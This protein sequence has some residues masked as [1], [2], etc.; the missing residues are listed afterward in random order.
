MALSL[1]HIQDQK[2]ANT[3]GGTGSVGDNTRDLNTVL[4]NEISGASLASNKITL[5]AGTYMIE[6]SSPCY[7]CDQNRAFLYNVTDSAVE[8][9]GT[10]EYQAESSLQQSRSFVNGRFT[11]AGSK[12]FELRHNLSAAPSSIQVLGI[13]SND[14]R[15]EVYTDVSIRQVVA[16]IPLLHV[17][18]QKAANTAG[19]S[20]SETSW[21]TRDLN[22][23]LTNEISG[24]SL[25]SDQITLPAGT[26][27]IEANTR[28]HRGG[29][30]RAVLYNVTDSAYEIIG[31][32]TFA[33]VGGFVEN[34]TFVLGQ[35]TISETKIF[36]LRHY[37]TVAVP[38]NGLG[39][40]N[41]DGSVEIYSDVIIRQT[42]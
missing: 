2:A 21:H 20:S 40:A 22:T 38:T 15:V 12:D 39:W 5:P 4:T 3:G 14:T 9:L 28:S 7:R 36:E 17:Q 10:V 24:A 13:A 19:G 11:I 23:V 16:A 25:A 42:A 33:N 37:I 18:D 1:L 31:T 8:V 35:F 30:H 27:E 6:A 29:A 26:Y 32:S 41:N 34:Q